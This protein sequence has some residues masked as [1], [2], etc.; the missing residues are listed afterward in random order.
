MAKL[1]VRTP[2]NFDPDSEMKESNLVFDP[3]TGEMK[4]MPSCTVP[5]QTISIRDILDRSRKGQII[6]GALKGS[7]DSTDQMPDPRSLDYVERQEMM[8]LAE[9]EL[10]DI[11]QR[12][13]KRNAD[14]A[15]KRAKERAE[16]EA[17][18]QQ[19]AAFKGNKEGDKPD[20][21]TNTP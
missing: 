11:K 9:R 2:Y 14:K 4:P 15:A 17:F 20:A 12:Q 3:E 19:L 16:F 18:K 5:D 13:D 21:G 8:E 1:K 7:F 6:S 10:A